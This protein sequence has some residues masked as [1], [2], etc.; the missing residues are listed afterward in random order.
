MLSWVDANRFHHSNLTL[1][2]LSVQPSGLEP[3]HS[4]QSSTTDNRQSAEPHSHTDSD[5]VAAHDGSTD[6][7]AVTGASSSSQQMSSEDDNPKT[8]EPEREDW[9]EVQRKRKASK[10]ELKVRVSICIVLYV[11]CIR[12]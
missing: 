7:A 1:V 9:V 10:N 2:S 5:K 12:Y 8:V 6:K 11:R 3:E 4:L